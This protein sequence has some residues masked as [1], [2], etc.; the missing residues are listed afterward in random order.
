MTLLPLVDWYQSMKID[1]TCLVAMTQTLRNMATRM[2]EIARDLRVLANH[3]ENA[4]AESDYLLFRVESLA[5]N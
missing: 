1:L 2:Q 3:A 5:D 4:C